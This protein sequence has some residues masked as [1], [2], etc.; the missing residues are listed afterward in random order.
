MVGAAA[1]VVSIGAVAVGTG[2]SVGSGVSVGKGVVV[3]GKVTVTRG[4]T[5]TCGC[6]E[7]AVKI[8]NEM[9]IAINKRMTASAGIKNFGNLY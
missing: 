3:G 2:V 4:V 1:S 7:Q 6:D 9:M 5:V 8:K